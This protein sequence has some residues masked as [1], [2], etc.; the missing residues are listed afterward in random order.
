L[1]ERPS[2]GERTLLVHLKLRNPSFTADLCEFRELAISAGAVVVDTV[3]SSV[4]NLDPKSLIGKG[5]VEEIHAMVLALD[6][7]LVLFNHDLTP[8]QE[9]NLEK[10]LQ[11][12]VL[13]RTGL[14]LD[15]FSQRARTF[16]GKLQVELAQLEHL[17]TRLVRGRAN[18]E[19]QKGGIGLRGPGEK[20]LEFDRRLIKEKI[21][22]I[23]CKLVKVREQ[24]QQNKRS[25]QKNNVPTV[26][27]VG[28]TNAGKSTLFNKITGADV[29]A[30]NKLFA[31][32][33]P[34]LRAIKVPHIGNTILAD[35]VGFIRDLPHHL[36]NA[37]QATLEETKDADLLLHVIDYH[38]E[39]WHEHRLQVEAVLKQIGALNVPI[40]E[41][42]NKIDLLN[43]DPSYARGDT[44]VITAV[45][46]SANNETGIDILL[47]SIAER[48]ATDVITG[49]LKLTPNFAKLRA[50]LYEIG[51]VD[52]ESLDKNG[53][54]LLTITLRNERWQA[55][56]REFNEL[57]SLL[58]R[59]K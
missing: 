26:A 7:N 41:V 29:Y 37:F 9:R 43:L 22:N 11:C 30:A 1:F 52:E 54:W 4:H 32:L 19:Q 59:K 45:Q 33:D 35:T 31:T 14:I 34:T 6:I 16:E 27:L 3:I 12:R 15:I 56:C 24:R 36:V 49:K 28:Y 51:A 18:L 13:D 8:T 58:K 57:E 55:L 25:R 2:S 38:D 42:Y 48:L 40:L 50:R 47:N 21:K 53:V 20:Q 5:K 44:G 23:N 46:V 39:L 10:T 17:S